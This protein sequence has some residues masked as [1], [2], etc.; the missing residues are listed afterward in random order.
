M[1]F[2]T[3]RGVRPWVM[4][5]MSYK[6]SIWPSTPGPAPMP[7]TGTESAWVMAVPTSLGTHSTSTISAPASCSALASSSI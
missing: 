4:S 5:K 2:F 7:M 3:K 1:K 6:T